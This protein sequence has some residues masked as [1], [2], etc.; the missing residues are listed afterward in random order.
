MEGTIEHTTTRFES[1][2]SQGRGARAMLIRFSD[3][4]LRMP[5]E[6][7]DIRGHR[8][9]DSSGDEIGSVEDLL[10]DTDQRKVRF[11]AV[12]SGGFLGIGARN[13]LIPVDAIQNFD[14]EKVHLNQT[15]Q[16][17][18]ESPDYDPTFAQQPDYEGFFGYYGYKP[19]WGPGYT[20]PAFPY[21]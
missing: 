13:F 10:I 6:R 11:L 16:F 9:L 5:D 20:Y 12:S 1:E 18:N 8:V 21:F 3:S 17:V 19:F 15:R 2:Q 7:M 4:D 14:S